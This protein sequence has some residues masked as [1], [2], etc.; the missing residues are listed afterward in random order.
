LLK[1]GFM[2][3]DAAFGG[4]IEDPQ[5]KEMRDPTPEELVRINSII[6]NKA[7]AFDRIVHQNRAMQ[8]QID[9]LNAELDGYR[10]SAPGAGDPPPAGAKGADDDGDPF[11][12]FDKK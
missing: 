1:I 4:Q 6:R 8:K 3:A 10:E 2:L 9:E 12:R 11:A 5:T 7:G